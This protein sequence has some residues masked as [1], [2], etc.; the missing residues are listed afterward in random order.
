MLDQ[1]EEGNPYYSVRREAVDGEFFPKFEVLS[2]RP[3]R[4]QLEDGQSVADLVV[5]IVQERDGYL[6]PDL[7]READTVAPQVRAQRHEF[8]P[9]F[10]FRGGCSLLV[11]IERGDLRYCISRDIL[12]ERRLQQQREFLAAHGGPLA[13]YFTHATDASGE[14]FALIHRTH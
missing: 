5:E 8:T 3:A 11:D 13:T 6:D 7:Q 9:D 10:I 1:S 2:V 4:R 12:S 14:P